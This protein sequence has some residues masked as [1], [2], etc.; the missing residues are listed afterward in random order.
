M[1]NK[2]ELL[3]RSM[4]LKMQYER[5]MSE[6]QKE[7]NLLSVAR[8]S[9]TNAMMANV[10]P[11]AEEQ[12]KIRAELAKYS[13]SSSSTTSSFTSSSTSSSAS[14]SSSSKYNVGNIH[15]SNN[16]SGYKSNNVER[17]FGS[18]KYQQR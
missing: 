5:E 7:A 15:V 13:P 11:I 12:H 14:A 10:H 2:E 9:L 8:T 18:H 1:A 4:E 3:K 16:N 17:A 6:Y